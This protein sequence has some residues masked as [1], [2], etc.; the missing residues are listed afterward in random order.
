MTRHRDDAAPRTIV[1]KIWD[2]HV[3]TEEPG[4]PAVLAIDL[5]LVHEVTTPQAFTGLRERG[6]ARPPARRRRSRPRTTRSRRRR[7]S[8]PMLDL[9][10]AA[11]IEPARAELRASSAS[12][13]TASARPA[14]ASSTSS[15]RSWA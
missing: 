7:A 8:L 14:R 6:L 13:S 9:Q 12:R 1:D 3:V 2:D 10:A 15:A 11:Q 5:H 4:A